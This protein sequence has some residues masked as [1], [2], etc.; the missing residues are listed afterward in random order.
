MAGV[1]RGEAAPK[2]KLVRFGYINLTGVVDGTFLKRGER[3]RGHEFHYWDSTN[4]G[5]DAKALKP[6]GKR[7]WECV[8]M[9]QNLFA[10]FPHLSYSSNPVFAERFMREAIRWEQ[11]QKEG[12]ERK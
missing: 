10:G 3:I 5:T 11:S 6:D 7:S 2:E 1:I 4:N 12:S 9:Q 8:H